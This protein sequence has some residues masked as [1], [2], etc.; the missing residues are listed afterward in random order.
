MEHS[1]FFGKINTLFKLFL[2]LLTVKF[3]F[4]IMIKII[5]W[6]HEFKTLAVKKP[7]ST[8]KKGEGRG[9][10]KRRNQKE[11]RGQNKQRSK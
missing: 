9:E 10:K 2:K 6:P 11:R 4:I 5:L 1:F 7:G 3:Y 8:E